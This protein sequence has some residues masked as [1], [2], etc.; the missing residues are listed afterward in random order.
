MKLKA[1]LTIVGMC[2]IGFLLLSISIGFEAAL[3]LACWGLGIWLMIAG[4]MAVVEML[5]MNT[6]EAL[7]EAQ[8]ERQG[9]NHA[10]MVTSARQRYQEILDA[11]EERE[12][13]ERKRKQDQDGNTF[14]V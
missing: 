13:L 5:R 9:K 3:M 6:D 11:H 1:V 14:E 8:A 7:A 2:G 12:R 4:F 10:T